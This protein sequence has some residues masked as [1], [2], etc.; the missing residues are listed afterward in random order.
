MERATHTTPRLKVWLL[1]T[2]YTCRALL[3]FEISVGNSVKFSEN[4]LWSTAQAFEARDL[5]HLSDYTPP[6]HAG[7][8]SSSSSFINFF[9]TF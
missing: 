3:T 2:N 7:R 9:Y 5:N 4:G 6:P 1:W 8:P